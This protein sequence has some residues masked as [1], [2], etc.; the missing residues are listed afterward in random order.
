M[1]VATALDAAR[2]VGGGEVKPGF[3]TPGLAFGAED[4]LS[5]EGV[6]REDL[7]A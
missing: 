4:I 2:R 3:Q 7:N 6:E 1:T 5:F